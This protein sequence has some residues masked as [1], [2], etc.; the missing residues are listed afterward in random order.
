[1]WLLDHVLVNLINGFMASRFS[2]LRSAPRAA[3]LDCGH[4]ADL[5]PAQFA[6]TF[7][8]SCPLQRDAVGLVG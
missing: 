6:P 7:R 4:G 3:L 1:M 8:L 5:R 2:V